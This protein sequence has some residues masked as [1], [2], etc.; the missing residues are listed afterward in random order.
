MSSL[1][2]IKISSSQPDVRLLERLLWVQHVCI[3]IVFLIGLLV[4]CGWMLPGVGDLLPSVWTQMKVSTAVC[5]YFV[6]ISMLLSFPKN[7]ARN[8]RQSR[9]IAALVLLIATL[10]LL[11]FAT[12]VGVTLSDL[13]PVTYTGA[14][15]D[16]MPAHTAIYLLLLSCCLLT[17]HARKNRLS[18]LADLCTM[19]LIIVTAII[20]AGYCFNVAGLFAESDVTRTSPQT[21]VCLVLLTFVHVGRRAESGFFSVL[22]GVGIGSRISRRALPI[23]LVVPFLSLLL[24]LQAVRHDWL[25]L[26]FGAALSAIVISM[27]LFSLVVWMAWHINRLERELRDMSLTDE[28]TK[29]YNRRGFDL[30]AEQALREARRAGAE[31][32]VLYLDLDGLKAINDRLGHDAGSDYI[33]EFAHALRSNFRDS[34]I[35][36]RLGGDEF[37]VVTYGN[38]DDIVLAERRLA[39]YIDTRNRQINGRYVIRYSAGLA[40]EQ[41]GASTTVDALLT[42]ADTRMYAQKQQHKQAAVT[43]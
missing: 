35:I 32:A 37:A 13:L 19:A 38:R 36:G 2:P 24:V 33:R 5:V 14:P 25:S 40:S 17:A 22:I 8:F 6:G 18:V 7:S 41:A 26:S 12:G 39:E 34:D 3:G 9:V 27:L 4:L 28:L 1:L 20:V 15:T 29:I 42:Q 10:S 21:V 16:R 23:V 30:F 11:K 43:Q 31:L